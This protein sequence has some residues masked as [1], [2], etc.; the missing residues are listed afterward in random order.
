MMFLFV[1]ISLLMLGSGLGVLLLRN[2]LNCALSLILHLL[3]VAALFAM[4]DAHFLATVQIIVYAGAIM[5]LVVFVLM[6]LNLK[7]EQPKPVNT[8]YWA[9]GALSGIGLLVFMVPALNQVFRVFPDPVQPLVGSAQ[10]IGKILY[11]KYVFAFEAAS[12]LIMAAIVG[13]VM[14]AKRKYRGD[15]LMPAEKR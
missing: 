12:I 11:T 7:I 6:L 9:V 5:V 2:P 8:L 4:L 3:M 1:L 13:A 15:P 14:I 10:A